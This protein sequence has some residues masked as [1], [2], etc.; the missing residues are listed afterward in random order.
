M[1]LQAVPP[2]YT[3]GK[4][5]VP[6]RLS[7]FDLEIGFSYEDNRDVD[8]TNVGGL[9]DL[10]ICNKADSPQDGIVAGHVVIT[11]A[12][13]KAFYEGLLGPREQFDVKKGTCRAFYGVANMQANV[14]S[15]GA[16]H[17]EGRAFMR[18]HRQ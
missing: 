16:P 1:R 18:A 17:W 13:Q 5:A 8:L 3:N 2:P 15:N 14:A 10:V 7:D 4:Y 11:P 6:I 12:Q 9:S